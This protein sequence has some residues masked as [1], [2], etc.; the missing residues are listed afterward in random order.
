MSLYHYYTSAS[1]VPPAGRG[2]C[3]SQNTFVRDHPTQ[4]NTLSTC[5]SHHCAACSTGCSEVRTPTKLRRNRPGRCLMW[6]AM[7]TARRSRRR[8][9]SEPTF[10]P[11]QITRR[12]SHLNI[13]DLDIVKIVPAKQNM[14]WSW[15][16]KSSTTKSTDLTSSLPSPT[17]AQGTQEANAAL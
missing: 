6:L 11:G 1:T 4:S 15:R 8:S 12:A 17:R 13:K 3:L 14:R 2:P 5:A 10:L 16:R 7:F 9:C